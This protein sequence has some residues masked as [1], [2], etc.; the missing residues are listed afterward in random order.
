[1]SKNKKKRTKPKNTGKI[2]GRLLRYMSKYTLKLLLVFVCMIVSSVCTVRAT[3][4]LKPA[5]NDYAVP[6]I[7]Q[8]DPDLSGFI[9]IIVIMAVLYALAVIASFIQNGFMV[10]IS[11]D[12]MCR[13]R[14][15]MFKR[16][17]TFP[18]KYYDTH[19]HGEIMSHYSNDI[20]SLSD[21]LRKGFPKI[22]EGFTTILT[23]MITIFVVDYRLALVVVVCVLLLSLLMKAIT[24]RNAGLFVDQQ[25]SMAEMNAYTEEMTSGRTEIKAFGREEAVKEAFSDINGRLFGFSSKADFFA[26]SLFDI[27]RG[28]TYIGY[29]IVAMAGCYWSILGLTDVGTVG[30]FLQYYKNLLSPMTSISKQVNNLFSA[31]AGAERIFEFLDE[32]GEPDE[33]K[34]TLV[35][36]RISG[37]DEITECEE[38]TGDY[39]WKFETGELKKCEGWIIFDHVDFGYN[40]DKQVLYD[41][42]LEVKPGQMVAFVGATGAG[43]TTIINLLSR[44][45]EI[46][47]GDILFDGINIR[48][49]RKYDLRRAA[50][51]VL[52]DTHLFTATVAENI[53]YGRL[54]A[55]KEEVEAAA[56]LANADYFIEH[57]PEEY[58]TVLTHDGSS[59][60][61]GERQLLAIA[62]ASI[63]EFPVL[64]LDEATSSIDSRTEMMVSEGLEKLMKGRTV[65]VIAHRLSTIKNADKIV[66]LDKGH[67]METGTHQE[68]IDKRGMYYKLYA[69]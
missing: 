14:V 61:Q 42:S 30:V 32:E 50:G 51:M 6:L 18:V 63:G 35:N 43:K 24:G 16:M 34:I 8:K 31:L 53:R 38:Y 9:K 45:Y 25:K 5:I 3:Y 19:K 36:C 4:Y 23:I 22:V 29:T 55:T 11:N 58:D 59:L 49:I 57:L 20:D 33:G 40:E 1:M 69:G 39:A 66:V 15:D 37:K 41:F 60:S 28:L 10:M 48:D 17:K 44:F 62:R 56:A 2:L 54:D 65:L 52:Q 7:G 46:Q 13:I 12:I 21:M 26:N 68:L 27:T 64:V 67:I 47:S